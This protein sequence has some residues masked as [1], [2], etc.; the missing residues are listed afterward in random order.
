MRDSCAA[1]DRPRSAVA[2]TL[3]SR[4]LSSG[5][6]LAPADHAALVADLAGSSPQQVASLPREALVEAFSLERVSR[7]NAVFDE[8]K[9]AWL[10]RRWIAATDPAGLAAHA[11]GLT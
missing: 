11:G 2:R 8:E 1:G 10:N 6:S 3:V 9:L 7:H 4:A 5:D